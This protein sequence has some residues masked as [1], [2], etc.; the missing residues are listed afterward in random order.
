MGVRKNQADKLNIEF[1]KS[2]IQHSLKYNYVLGYK[3]LI[4]CK[5]S[6][7]VCYG[8]MKR[9]EFHIQGSMSQPSTRVRVAK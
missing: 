6:I 8:L 3:K 9:S 4:Y 1:K 7:Q 5:I 2:I